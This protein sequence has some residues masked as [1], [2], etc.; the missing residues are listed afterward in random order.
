[1]INIDI[2]R[3]ENELFISNDLNV[4]TS[5][6][7]ISMALYVKRVVIIHKHFILSHENMVKY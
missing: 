1:M 7:F 2:E 5:D 3:L 4:V 6:I